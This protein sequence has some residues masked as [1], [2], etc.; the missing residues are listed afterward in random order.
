MCSHRN[1]WSKDQIVVVLSPKLI[2]KSI[3]GLIDLNELFMSFLVSWIIL[4]MILDG[5][6]SVSSFDII[7]SGVSLEPKGSKVVVQGIWEMLIEE[8]LLVLVAKS[9]LIEE[10]IKGGVCIFKAVFAT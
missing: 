7:K 5:K 9:M 3:I 8:F 6:P 2:A 10:S 4:R 1:H